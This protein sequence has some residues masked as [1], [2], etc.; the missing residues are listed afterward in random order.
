MVVHLLPAVS[1]H[2]DVRLVLSFLHRSGGG[3]RAAQLL[4]LA[5]LRSS[6]EMRLFKSRVLELEGQIVVVGGVIP[7]FENAED[8]VRG[9]EIRGFLEKSG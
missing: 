7:C 4:P 5:R 8:V 6:G 3:A 9:R 1:L 2:G